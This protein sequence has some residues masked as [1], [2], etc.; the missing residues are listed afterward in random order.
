MEAVT[1]SQNKISSEKA[2]GRKLR[3]NKTFFNDNFSPSY[4]IRFRKKKK[5]DLKIRQRII[6]K[7]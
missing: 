1:G 6:E 3:N 5:E 2:N 7:N 4:L